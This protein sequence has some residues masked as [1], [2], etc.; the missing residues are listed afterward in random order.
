MSSVDL[1]A[2][3]TASSQSGQSSWTKGGTPVYLACFVVLGLSQLLG[4][5]LVV[6][7]ARTGLSRG[8]IGVL[9]V[10]GSL[11]YLFGT[12]GSGQ[13]IERLTPNRVIQIGL[14]IVVGA[15]SLA[16]FG[17]TL[18]VLGVAQFLIGFGAGLVDTSINT[19]ILWMHGGG[20]IMSAL[21]MCFSVGSLLGPLVVALSDRSTGE[22]RACYLA[23]GAAAVVLLFLVRRLND[24]KDPHAESRSILTGSQRRLLVLAV[25]FYFVYVGIEVGFIGWVKEF[26]IA[27]GLAANGRATVLNT[28]FLG[29]FAI[30]RVASIPISRFDPR[31]VLLVDVLLCV[32]GLLI[33]IA[34]GGNWLKLLAGCGLFGLGTASMFP[35]MLAMMERRMPTSGRVTSAILSGAA[36]GA[37]V[38]PWGIGKGF[39]R[40]GP[41]TLPWV[42]LVGTVVCGC[43]AWTFEH[44]AER[45]ASS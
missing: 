41:E 3:P 24:P 27:Q 36:V 18:L 6:F 17:A 43:F 40:I 29:A 30:G 7:Q 4:P 39:D 13:V 28:V 14:V 9:F 10:F 19:V 21:H 2:H 20:P 37:M 8:A 33:L 11:G 16:A 12:L 35:V 44:R 31:K 22:L 25:A 32:A 26:G 23:I 1:R 42:V 34:G 15:L 38:L 45:Q 5:S